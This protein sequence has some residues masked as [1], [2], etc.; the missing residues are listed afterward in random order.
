M[1]ASN[2]GVFAELHR[3]F[4]CRSFKICKKRIFRRTEKFKAVCILT[5]HGLKDPD[6][7]V[8]CSSN[9]KTLSKYDRHY[10]CNRTLTGEKMSEEIKKQ[11]IKIEI[12]DQTANGTYSNLALITH[13]E[14]EF[15][16]DFILFSL[17]TAKQKSEAEL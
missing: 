1:I 6:R 7:A 11:E 8:I 15:V 17:K 10:K 14:T 3:I 4:F 13:S 12:D 16:I 9:L 5:G 2:E